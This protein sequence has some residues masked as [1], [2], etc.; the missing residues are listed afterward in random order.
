MATLA[1]DELKCKSGPCAR[2][3][4][5]MLCHQG[6]LYLFGGFY[7]NGEGAPKYFRD[8]WAFDLESLKWESLGDMRQARTDAR[9][10]YAEHGPDHDQLHM[11]P[12]PERLSMLPNAAGV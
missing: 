10:L 8:L 11:L 9:G 6:R 7:D 12:A 1:W 4:H 5:R 2:S 3:G